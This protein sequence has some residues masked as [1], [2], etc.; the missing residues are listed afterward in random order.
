MALINPSKFIKLDYGAQGWSK[1]IDLNLRRLNSVLLYVPQIGDVHAPSGLQDKDILV[2][3]SATSK[4][5]VTRFYDYFPFPTA[6]GSV[7]LADMTIVSDD[8]SAAVD[9]NEANVLTDF[10]PY[11]GKITITDSANKK[12]IGYAKAANGVTGVTITSTAGGTTFNWDTKEAGFNYS[13]AS[14][15]TYTLEGVVEP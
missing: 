3:N 4:W 13:D 9:F 15:Y 6:D 7:A 2:W 8:G 5:V 12:L 11:C 14:G 1:I 10:I